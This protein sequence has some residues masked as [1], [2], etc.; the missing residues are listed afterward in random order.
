M[1]MLSF[2]TFCRKDDQQEAG[3]IIGSV[4]LSSKEMSFYEENL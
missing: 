4:Y 3:K 1:D 2:M